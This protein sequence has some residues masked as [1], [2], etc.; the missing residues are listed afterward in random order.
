MVDCSAVLRLRSQNNSTMK[1]A[2]FTLLERAIL[3]AVFISWLAVSDAQ[4][5]EKA[6]KDPNW[7]TQFAAVKQ[8]GNFYYACGYAA[9]PTDGIYFGDFSKIDLNGNVVHYFDASGTTPVILWSKQFDEGETNFSDPGILAPTANKFMYFDTRLGNPGGTGKEVF[10]T[11]VDPMEGNC[12][13]QSPVYVAAPITLTRTTP[14]VVRQEVEIPDAVEGVATLVEY[15]ERRLCELDCPKSCITNTINLNTGQ[16]KFYGQYD[17]SWMLIES[18]DTNMNLPRAANVI[19]ACWPCGWTFQNNANWISAF[20]NHLFWENNPSPEAAYVFENCFCSCA[21]SALATIDLSVLADDAVDIDLYSDQGIFLQDITTVQ[22]FG[23][24]A[25]SSNQVLLAQPGTYCV[26]AALRNLSNVALG[27]NIVGSVTGN[28]LLKREC[29]RPQNI[30]QGVK[31]QDD[32]GDGFRDY[33]LNLSPSQFEPGIAGWKIM[34]C[35]QLGNTIQTV[36]TDA[37]GYYSFVGVPPGTY[38]L[39]EENRS[40][41]TQTEPGGSGF[42]TFTIDAYGVQENKAFGNRMTTSTQSPLT[43]KLAVIAPNPTLDKLK[44]TLVN[45][46]TYSTEVLLTDL[47][48]RTWQ[49]HHLE[50]GQ[51][52]L[53]L[54]TANLPGGAY[55]VRI[56]RNGLLLWAARFVKL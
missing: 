39:K 55:I 12:L 1:S 26:R 51:P 24:P 36:E 43:A 13:T 54:N 34:L 9:S 14:N 11:Q 47:Q 18:P 40:G 7:A 53:E 30:I 5:F 2:S 21:D 29:C 10:L 22:S 15:E 4:T 16:D 50:A 33:N 19:N 35:D 28:Q 17:A 52:T 38:M 6:F 25:P 48:G 45:A 56:Q 46:L 20:P 31:Y 41:W 32:D 37:W 42:Y 8:S 49:K 23:T 27:L 44:L 3:S